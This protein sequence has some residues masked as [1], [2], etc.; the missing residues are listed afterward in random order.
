[1]LSIP[2]LH[3]SRNTVRSEGKVAAASPKAAAVAAGTNEQ[4][5][6]IFAIR[7]ASPDARRANGAVALE[8]Q[9]PI[10]ICRRYGRTSGRMTLPSSARNLQF[11]AA[12]VP[13]T[14]R[15]RLFAE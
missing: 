15:E 10:R 1:M 6:V 5:R 4:M 8:L 13:R 12:F 3:C 14:I 2:L 7:P 9:M 11:D